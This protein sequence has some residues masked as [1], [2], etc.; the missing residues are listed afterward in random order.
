MALMTFVFFPAT[1]LHPDS[2]VYWFGMQIGMVTG[3]FTAWPVNTWLIRA[4]IKKA[5]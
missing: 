4:G 3:F 1:H 5:M 2:A